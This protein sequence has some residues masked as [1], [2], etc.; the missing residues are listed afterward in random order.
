[1]I[2][3]QHRYDKYSMAL[4]ENLGHITGVC[5]AV[6]WLFF[7]PDGIHFLP[8]IAALFAG[9]AIGAAL[10]INRGSAKSGRKELS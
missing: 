4:T 6:L 9:A 5:I 7:L 8:I 1:M 3:E 10:Y 2:R